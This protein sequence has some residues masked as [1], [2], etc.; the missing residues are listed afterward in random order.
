MYDHEVHGLT[1][2]KQ[3]KRIIFGMHQSLLILEN[4]GVAKQ[5]KGTMLKSRFGLSK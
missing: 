2:A 1:W 5:K 3:F 4:G